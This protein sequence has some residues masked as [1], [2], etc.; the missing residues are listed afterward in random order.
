M[1]DAYGGAKPKTRTSERSSKGEDWTQRNKSIQ[2][3]F[4]RDSNEM[5]TD[6]KD[7]S[8]SKSRINGQVYN[9]EKYSRDIQD[10]VHKGAKPKISMTTDLEMNSES[11]KPY[12]CHGMPMSDRTEQVETP[13]YKRSQI[14]KISKER[15]QEYLTARERWKKSGLALRKYIAEKLG[16]KQDKNKTSEDVNMLLGKEIRQSPKKL[17]DKKVKSKQERYPSVDLNRNGLELVDIQEN[18]TSNVSSKSENDEF[19]KGRN[20]L[21]RS[22]SEGSRD[23]EVLPR[24]RSFLRYLGLKKEKYNSP[25]SGQKGLKILRVL[26]CPLV[27]HGLRVQQ[28]LVNLQPLIG[29]LIIL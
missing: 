4:L 17:V 18:N 10:S 14:G 20:S 7:T 16:F 6:R 25:K 28:T 9:T 29:Q 15:E 23:G 21:E 2:P 5:V 24:S 3:A 12:S 8:C 11:V 26:K 19:F 1:A 22:R 13:D 27:M